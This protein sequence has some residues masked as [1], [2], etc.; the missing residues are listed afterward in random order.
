MCDYTSG[1]KK[2]RAG[3]NRESRRG[4]RRYVCLAVARSRNAAMPFRLA[5]IRL[6][7]RAEWAAARRVAA[8]GEREQS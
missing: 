2:R 5:V 4:G 8:V 6:A 1:M 7:D 3:L